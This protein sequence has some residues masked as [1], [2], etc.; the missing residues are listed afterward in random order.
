MDSTSIT[1]TREV[2]LKDFSGGLN[3][4]WDPS[5][6]S[7][8]EVSAL[9]NMEFTPNGAL[10]SRPPIVDSGFDVPVA[11]QYID[12]LGYYMTSAGIRY[13]VATTDSKTWVFNTVSPAW[14]EIWAYKATGYVQYA[15]EV[16]LCGKDNVGGTRWKPGTGS[17]VISGMPNLDGLLVYRDRMFGWGVAG[18]QYQTTFYYSNV[19]TLA[20]ATGVY[21]WDTANNVAVVGR[22]DGQAITMMLAD[23]DKILSLIHI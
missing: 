2:A 4:Y 3:N 9:V 23:T 22:G 21:E 18:T 6:I 20:N 7:D 15:E 14:T 11:G 13:L 17:T 1:R 12:I 8:N 16:V 19:I 5:S 10:Q